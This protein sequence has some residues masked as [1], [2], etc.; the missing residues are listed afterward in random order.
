MKIGSFGS[1][2]SNMVVNRLTKRFGGSKS[3]HV[4]RHRSDQFYFYHVEKNRQI[5]PREYIEYK[6][7]KLEPTE[8]VRAEANYV[9]LKEVLDNQYSKLGKHGVVSDDSFFDILEK[10]SL[11]IIIID[12]YLDMSAILSYPKDKDFENSPV[13]LRKDFFSNYDEY[14]TFGDK[15]SIQDSMFYFTKIIEFFRSYQ[16]NAEIYFLNYPYNTY[17]NNVNRQ[18]RAKQFEDEFSSSDATVVPA[19]TISKNFQIENDPAH[20]DDSIYVAYSGFI[21][22]NYLVKRKKNYEKKIAQ[23]Q[24]E[25]EKASKRFLDSA[26]FFQSCNEYEKIGPFIFNEN[27]SWTVALEVLEKNND[28]QFNFFFGERGTVGHSLVRIKNK[29]YYRNSSGNYCG[30]LEFPL[31][32]VNEVAVIYDAGSIK[33][34]VNGT[35][36]EPEQFTSSAT[37]DA[38]GSGYTGS[39]NEQPTY[40]NNVAI[41][42]NS[43]SIGEIE[44]FF[45]GGK[46]QG[47]LSPLF[48]FINR[49]NEPD[50]LPKTLNFGY[51]NFNRVELKLPLD[52][53]MDPFS[54]NNWCHNF[55]SLRWVKSYFEQWLDNKSRHLNPLLIVDDFLKYHCDEK[56]TKN[57]FYDSK[58]ADHTLSERLDFFSFV[59]KSKEKNK[60]YF[61]LIDSEN[62][63]F[64]VERH[65][66]LMC[67]SDVY[68][69]KSNHG[70][71]MDMSLIRFALNHPEHV[72]CSHVLSTAEERISKQIDEMFDR[73]GF[74]KEHSISYQEFD[75]A[76]C[77]DLLELYENFNRSTWFTERVLRIIATT[78]HFL[79]F[80]RKSNGEYHRIGDS[81]T[82]PNVKLWEKIENSYSAL[83]TRI[84]NDYESIFSTNEDINLLVASNAGFSVIKA[85]CIQRPDEII[86]LFFTASWHSYVHKQNDDLSFSLFAYGKSIIDDPGYSDV[87]TNKDFPFSSEYVHNVTTLEGETWKPRTSPIR[88][89]K[90]VAA[91][92]DSHVSSIQGVQK[93]IKNVVVE[94]TIFCFIDSIFLIVDFI[95]NQSQSMSL[96]ST[97]FNFGEE[98]T[99][100]SL[101][102]SGVRF[103]PNEA[104]MFE[105]YQLENDSFDSFDLIDSSILKRD[106]SRIQSK[107]ISYK[108][109]IETEGVIVTVID[110]AKKI[111]HLKVER[112][113]S[114]TF[115]IVLNDETSFI[116][117][118]PL[119]D[120]AVLNGNHFPN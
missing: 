85:G 58:L 83:P 1:C 30:S 32:V 96:F 9:P 49:E 43:L 28:E 26:K 46:Y 33:F 72:L 16:P 78:Y 15:I 115:E 117:L 75:A 100:F 119:S 34:Y 27:E 55:Y 108:N 110:M 38:I 29:L 13:F 81:F 60:E 93:R 12:N 63:T 53:S 99:D 2:L 87:I 67:S 61:D 8:K 95:E 52:W 57:R 48:S 94:R 59:I 74:V 84:K 88:D 111:E 35:L 80:A 4:Y 44:C 118:M 56:T 21:Y 25:K 70:F 31:E 120:N 54:N 114:C 42:N 109:K 50:K 86:N 6:L 37:F 62:L 65:L 20:F 19:A 104:K 36:S 5:V 89:T 7:E 103:G 22:F 39:G 17:I 23:E 14:F 68:R 92:S 116:E 82:F 64:I 76:L 51:R 10:Q 112:F 79:D 73:N 69:E 105:L 66:R 90:L 47:F 97:R 24:V 98:M 107:S 40:I 71:M 18:K 11:D 45:K 106:G 102:N 113:D 91:Y 101:F 41:W 3:F 77:I